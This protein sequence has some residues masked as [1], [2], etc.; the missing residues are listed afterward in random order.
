MALKCQ[1]IYALVGWSVCWSFGGTVK[2]TNEGRELTLTCFHRST[3]FTFGGLLGERG[4]ILRPE[5]IDRQK[6]EAYARVRFHYT[7]ILKF[8]KTDA[9]SQTEIRT[10]ADSSDEGTLA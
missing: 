3:Y 4:E 8:I 2:I 7:C 1:K 6:L 5:N 10:E 9:R